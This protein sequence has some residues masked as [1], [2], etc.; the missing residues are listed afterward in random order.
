MWS[1]TS[2]KEKVTLSVGGGYMQGGGGYRQRN[3]VF[4]SLTLGPHLQ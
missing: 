3:M 2:V 4:F 1:N